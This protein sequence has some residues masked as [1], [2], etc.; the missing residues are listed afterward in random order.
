M[1]PG[2]NIEIVRSTLLSALV[3]AEQ[4]D[5]A[6]LAIPGFAGGSGGLSPADSALVVLEVIKAHKAEN[7]TKIILTDQDENVIEAIVK[8]LEKYDEEDE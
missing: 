1:G 3:L 8:A 7:V 5:A 2:D 4:L 6:T